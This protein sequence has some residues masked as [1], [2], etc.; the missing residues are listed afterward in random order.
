MQEPVL[1]LM[2]DIDTP[3]LTTIDVYEKTLG[4]YQSLK[5]LFQTPPEEIVEMVKASGLRGRGGAGFPTGLKWSFLAKDVFPRYLCCN[6]DESEPGTCK[7]RELLM[8]NPHLLIEGMIICSYACKIN[9]AYN[10]MRGEFAELA[11]IFD[12]AVE[13]A[14]ARG[15]L[16]KNIM[17]SGFDLDIHSHLGAGAYICGEESALLTSLEGCRGEPRLKPPFPAV[18]GLYSKPTVVNNVETL[19]AVPYIFNNGPEAYAAIGTEKSK[20]TKMVSVSGH[21][22]KPGNYEVPMGTPTREII[23]KWAGGMRNGNKLK[24][25]IPG[26]SSVPILPADKADVPYDYES[27][28]EAGS[29]LGSGALIVMDE[30][31]NVVEETL[32][33]A[34]F[35]MHESCGKCTPCREGTRW[36]HQILSE[37]IHKQGKPNQVELLNDICDN[38]AFKC[39]CPLG[40]AAVGP[41]ASS[42][43]YF[44]EDYEALIES[45][46]TADA[47]G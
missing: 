25:F 4:G 41:V 42:I 32:R 12:K 15:Y 39:F 21:V 36:M 26:G 14:Y 33:L 5:K 23:D 16:G 9:T 11:D 18:E 27:L 43:Q 35:Y 3:N 2:K 28:M 6:A 13:E 17:G 19:C 24:A 47:V 22:N 29:M 1:I 38:M 10:Y 30:T 44:R 20:G 7:D 40:D 45:L 34:Y 31:V 8:K 46:K 37:I